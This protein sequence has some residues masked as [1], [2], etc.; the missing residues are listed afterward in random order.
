MEHLHAERARSITASISTTRRSR[1]CPAAGPAWPWP[2]TSGRCSGSPLYFSVGSEFAHL[3]Q[4]QQGRTTRGN[5][6]SAPIPASRVSTSSPQIRYPFKKWQWL[7]ANSAAGLARHVLH[8]AASRRSTDR[9]C[10][11]PIVIDEPLEPA[12]LHAPDADRR[13]GLQ[14]DLGY[15]EQRLRREVQAHGR[16]VPEPCSKHLVD[17][18]FPLKS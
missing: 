15:A 1:A 11:R 10:R 3:L 5:S 17:R 8:A 14:S 16:A 2:E 7:T 18:Q 6:R 9:T 4:R 12:V 13:A